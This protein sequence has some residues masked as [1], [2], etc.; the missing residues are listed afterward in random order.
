MAKKTNSAPLWARGQDAYFVIRGTQ[1]RFC[2]KAM[3]ACG[4]DLRSFTFGDP[5][6][7]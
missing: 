4:V 3:F 5:D 7:I 1:D 6:V 2:P